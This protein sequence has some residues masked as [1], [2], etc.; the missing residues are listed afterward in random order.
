MN[1]DIAVRMVGA[2]HLDNIIVHGDVAER[3]SENA[4][5]DRQHQALNTELETKFVLFKEGEPGEK[6]SL[7]LHRLLCSSH[8][9]KLDCFTR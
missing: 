8:R 3:W 6:L 7:Y 4:P 5:A 2:K 1:D 9:S